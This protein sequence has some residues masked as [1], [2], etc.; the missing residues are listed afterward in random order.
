MSA[1]DALSRY[2]EIAL[3]LL[4]KELSPFVADVTVREGDDFANDAALFFEA[5]LQSDAPGDFDKS[6][7][8][9]HLYLRRELE[10]LGE[11]RF[12]YLVTRRSKGDDRPEDYILKTPEGA[13][14]KRPAAR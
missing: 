9:A 11:S 8:L 12:P 2:R 1:R 6:F 10:G 4:R 7:I 14:A 5:H 3:D 13:V